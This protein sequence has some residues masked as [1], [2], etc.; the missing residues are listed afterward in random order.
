MVFVVGVEDLLRVSS[1][2]RH[3]ERKDGSETYH[4]RV[5]LP[6]C[7]QVSPESSEGSVISDNGAVVATKVVGVDDRVAAS[8]GDMCDDGGV[9]R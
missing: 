6:C 7:S 1:L 5:R 9:V 2:S 3:A 8:I 4:V